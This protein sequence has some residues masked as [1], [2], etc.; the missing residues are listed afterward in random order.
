M[1]AQTNTERV[2]IKYG[3]NAMRSEELQQQV[4]DQVKHLVEAGKQ[5]II[6][7]GGGPFIK[8]MLEVA[9]IESE[10][11]D[12]HRRTTAEALP[13]IEM[14]LKGQ[15]NGQLVRL[16]NRK[17]LK[18]VG[19]S[20]KDGRLITAGKR[21]YVTTDGDQ[22]VTHDL[23]L[24]GDVVAI[25]TKI[26]DD[27][28]E[29]GYV[30]VVTCIASDEHGQDY[31]INADMLAG[32]LAGALSVDNYLVLTDVDGLLREIKEPGSLIDQLDLT[33]LRTLISEI[34]QGGMIPKLESCV[35]ALEKGAQ[36]AVIINGMKPERILLAAT[37]GDATGTYMTA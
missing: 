37:S 3:G 5:P 22:E 11:I 27:L 4:I 35:V 34:A 33:G 29:K 12:G 19:L 2:L 30:P 8:R 10:F 32:H 21:A 9:G 20:G 14:A 26:I 28:L 1:T 7:H 15:V 24:V 36:Q 31:N 17:G 6:V 13:F 18:A 25:D 23:G 16:L